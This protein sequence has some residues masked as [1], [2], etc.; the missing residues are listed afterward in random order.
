MS[1]ID[2]ALDTL[3]LLSERLQATRLADLARELR[4]P[5]SSAHRILAPLVRRGLAEQDDE[6]RYRAGFALLALGLNVVS[7]EPLAAAAK[8]VLESAAADLGETFFLVVARAGK[9]VVVEKAEGNGFLRA[10]P[11]L[12][13]EVPVHATAVGKL[14]LAFA[15]ELVSCDEMERYTTATVRSRKALSAE[16]ARVRARGWATNIE[17][18]QAGLAVAAAPIL[19]H[20]RLYG[21][22]ALATVTA[23]FTAIG[24]ASATRRV[25][26][27]A[28]GI[29][30]RIEGR[31]S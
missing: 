8:P 7:R 24:T 18:W 13:S 25:M 15:P 17:E 4:M 31:T 16:V 3:F 30:L 14:Y 19:S 20:G 12:G 23:R 5:R 26:H 6:G 22:V 1:T 28:E 11:R 2:K 27:A 21:T 29:A 9:L 10:A